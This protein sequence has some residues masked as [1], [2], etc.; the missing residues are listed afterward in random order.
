MMRHFS[1]FEF[2]AAWG[3]AK[4][5]TSNRFLKIQCMHCQSWT[6]VNYRKDTV[7]DEARVQVVRPLASFLCLED[8]ADA[9]ANNSV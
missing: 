6:L 8:A 4:S 1:D 2:E 9:A 7:G 3:S 5:N